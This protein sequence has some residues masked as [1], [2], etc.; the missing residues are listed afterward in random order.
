MTPATWVGRDSWNVSGG[1]ETL[2]AMNCRHVTPK[3]VRPERTLTRAGLW[4]TGPVQ[5]QLPFEA[6]GL[7]ERIQ[8]EG[9]LKLTPDYDVFAWLCERWQTRPTESGWMRPTLYASLAGSANPIFA[10]NCSLIA[11]H[12]SSLRTPSSAWSESEQCHTSAS[13]T[14]GTAGSSRSSCVPPPPTSTRARRRGGHQ[15]PVGALA[16]HRRRH[17]RAERAPR[18]IKDLRHV[19]RALAPERDASASIG[20]RRGDSRWL[21]A[22]QRSMM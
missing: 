14:R 9:R 5:L 15:L 1:T 13:F 8:A 7:S 19:L 17:P 6:T 3:S 21:T 18:M 16:P 2:P 22:V 4:A 12:L 10:T 20:S 11:A